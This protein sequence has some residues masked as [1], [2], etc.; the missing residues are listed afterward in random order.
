MKKLSVVLVMML[1]FAGAMFA[2]NDLQVLTVVNYSK[3]ESIT[4]KQLKA[5]CEIYEKQMGKKLTVD[6]KKMVLKALVEEKLVVQAAVKAGISIPDSS[7]DQYFMQTMSAQVGANVTEKELNDLVMKQEGITLDALLKKQTGM[8]VAEYKAYLKNQLI[9]QQY[10]VTQKQEDIAKVAATDEEIRAFYAGNK[11]SFVWND[12]VKAFMVITPKGT[13]PDAAKNTLT[14]LRNKYVGK[15][16]TVEQFVTESRKE[17]SKYQAGELLLPITEAGAAGIGMSY[18]NLRNLNE[19]KEG[20][21]SDVQ[22]TSTDFRFIVVE[23]KYAAK[24]LAISDVI[25]PETTVTVYNYIKDNLTQQKQLLF[26]QQ[27]AQQITES[28]NKPEY[29]TAKKSGA[30]LDALLNW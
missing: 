25:Q 3:S 12:M 19:Q 14:G 8:N 29:V 2:Q 22:E 23:K 5:R 15:T 10:V 1:A 30:D 7:I 21:V 18:N 6:E 20:F 11:T 17:G 26:V 24:M 13:D 4:V 28:L 27:A 9:A 16:M